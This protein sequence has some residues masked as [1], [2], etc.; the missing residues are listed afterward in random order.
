MDARLMEL[1]FSEIDS[2][3][4]DIDGEPEFAGYYHALSRLFD[5][6]WEV[7]DHR[8]CNQLWQNASESE[9]SYHAFLHF[10]TEKERREAF[11]SFYERQCEF[12]SNI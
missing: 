5:Q 9:S 10:G 1:Y 4:L 2:R 12:Y 11:N 3:R 8:T 7:L 6:L